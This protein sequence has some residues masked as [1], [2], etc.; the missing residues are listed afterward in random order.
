MA[1]LEGYERVYRG[2]Q[3]DV[4]WE[5]ANDGLPTK[6][7]GREVIRPLDIPVMHP[8]VAQDT[9]PTDGKFKNIPFL[10]IFK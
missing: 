10:V 9:P 8:L 1:G 6:Y 7:H 2:R 5:A 4:S 3:L